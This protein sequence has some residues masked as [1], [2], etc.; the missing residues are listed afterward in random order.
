M[1]KDKEEKEIILA[2]ELGGQSVL[3]YMMKGTVACEL[4]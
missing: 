3:Q 1:E 2:L 4:C